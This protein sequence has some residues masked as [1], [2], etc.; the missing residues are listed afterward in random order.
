M[1]KAVLFV[2]F[3]LLSLTSIGQETFTLKYFGMTIHPFGDRT[4]N[5]QPYKL[6]KNARFVAN[7]GGFVGYEKF[8]FKE[9][10]S[11]K[12]IQGVFTDCSAGWQSVTHLGVRGLMYENSKYRAYLAVGPTFIVRESW[13]RFGEE[14]NSSGYFKVK[15]TD[16]LGVIQQK[17]VWYGMEMEL[18]RIIDENNSVS[19]SFTPG[20]PMAVVF[21]IGWKH[22]FNRGEFNY[23][24]PVTPR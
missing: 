1:P 7:F 9:L 23:D 3:F 11:V 6:D 17:L 4:A 2:W 22:W 8:V 24:R 20:I 14:Y 15:T 19:L 13:T 16:R 21:S 18:D 5:L 10:I 12:F